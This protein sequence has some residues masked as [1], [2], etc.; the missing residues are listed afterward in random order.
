M[1]EGCVFDRCAAAI[2]VPSGA[3]YPHPAARLYLEDCIVRD[4][5]G[6]A[7]VTGVSGDRFD[8]L[9][10]MKNVYL[11]NV[12]YLARWPDG[13]APPIEGQAAGWW[14]ADFA[15][16]GNRWVNTKAMGAASY[17]RITRNCPAPS[18]TAADYIDPIP[19]RADCVSVSDFG[20]KGDSAHD[21]TDAI[22]TAIAKSDRPIFFPM[23][24]YKVSDTIQ[25][26]AH[27][28]LIGEH[29]R[30]TRI[31]LAPAAGDRSFDDPAHPK[32]IIDTVDDTRGTAVLARFY[33]GLYHDDVSTP[34]IREFDG[35]VNIRWRVGRRSII[36]DLHSHNVAYQ[37]EHQTGYA[38]L[39]LTGSGGGHIRQV[40]A[41]WYRGSG[42]G[43]I[44]I[45]GTTEPMTL[46]GISPEHNPRAPAIYL[47]DARNVTFR[48]LQSEAGHKIIEAHNSRGLA[49]NSIHYN[50]MKHIRSEDMP[51][52]MHF[53]DCSDFEIYCY[54]RHW[55]AYYADALLLE[56]NGAQTRL[57]ETGIAAYTVD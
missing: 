34:D 26:L 13:S 17:S 38:P 16:H 21:D 22:R 29:S 42:P 49:F 2:R 45:D 14:R 35:M 47:K 53:V 46:Y 31:R 12:R 18:F 57:P 52:A 19:S 37:G 54:W 50:L 24:T 39:V 44:I 32:P 10:A 5:T 48:Q 3:K 40:W 41:P 28:K 56:R 4:T 11:H 25:L 15:S 7:A 36:D 43:Q 27:T 55:S 9:M 1:L 8:W 30:R 23:G 20:A 6:E 51:P 33:F